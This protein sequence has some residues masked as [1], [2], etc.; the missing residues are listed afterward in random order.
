MRKITLH[1]FTLFS[2]MLSLWS[3]S[4]QNTNMQKIHWRVLGVLPSSKTGTASGLAGAFTGAS[5]DLMWIAGGSNF[6]NGL[7]WEGGSKLFHDT[8]YFFQRNK[9]G[10]DLLPVR[11]R[12]PVALAYG[13]SIAWKNGVVCVGGQN[14]SGFSNKVFFAYIKTGK[15]SLQ[16]KILPDLPAGLANASGVLYQHTLYI[17]GGETVDGP[18]DHFLSLDISTEGAKWKML[19]KLPVAVSHAI[20]VVQSNGKDTSLYLVGG[21]RKDISGI[22]EF[23]AAVYH[24]DFITASWQT[25]SSMPYA[26]SAHTGIAFEG[27]RILIFGGDKGAVFNKVEKTLVAI[28]KENDPRQK[29]A[30]VKIKNE[31]QN[32]HPGFSREILSYH[33]VTGKWELSDVLPFPAPVTTTAFIWNRS[34]IIPSGEVKAGIRSPE[35][36]MGTLQ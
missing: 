14:Q 15:P 10:M 25:C 28:G 7:P 30:L 33:T 9:N 11:G 32:S 8:V 34:I 3:I 2:L 18:T 20:M 4:A 13:T 17:A 31:L 16:Y 6:S 21:R 12:L 36:W 26:L 27:N 29:A 23:Y 1:I 19:P 22:S 5:G 35:I 24:Y